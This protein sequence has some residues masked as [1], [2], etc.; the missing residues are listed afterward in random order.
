M[1][2][3]LDSNIPMYAAGSEHPFK[4]PSIELLQRVAKGEV[5]AVTD[6]EVFQEI[7][8]RF[9]AIKRLA[10]GFHLFDAFGKVV[11][12]V[13]PVEHRDVTAA[14]VV[15]EGSVSVS[16]RDA[17]HIAV[18]KRYGISVVYSYDRHFD[19]VEGIERREPR[20]VSIAGQSPDD[21]H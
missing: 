12:T 3:F 13:L 1:R 10:E 15:L 6:A 18:M 9:S 2:V 5:D 7:L 19:L 11:E 8:H 20:S 21:R 4:E 16:A 17:I 14:R